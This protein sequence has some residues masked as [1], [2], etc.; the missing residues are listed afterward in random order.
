MVC[1]LNG[2]MIRSLLQFPIER[3][4]HRPLPSVAVSDSLPVHKQR[5]LVIASSLHTC[6]QTGP[7]GNLNYLSEKHLFSDFALGGPNPMGLPL[8]NLTAR[9]A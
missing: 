6:N 9:P 2:K 3:K 5:E 4:P 7:F 1:S 8:V